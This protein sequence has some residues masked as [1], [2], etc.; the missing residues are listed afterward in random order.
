VSAPQQFPIARQSAGVAPPRRPGSVRRTTSIDSTWPD[1]AAAPWIMDGRARDILTPADGSDPVVLDEAGYRLRISPLREILELA[2]QPLDERTEQLIGVRAG[3]ESRRRIV[4][5]IGDRAG[6]PLYQILDDFAGASLVARWIWSQW[7]EDWQA[8]ANAPEQQQSHGR[9]GEMRDI[10]TGFAEGSSALGPDGL[11]S[12]NFLDPARVGPLENPDDPAGW[13]AMP[14]Q[15]GPAMRRARRIDVWREA[16]LLMVDAGFQDS[17]TS[18]SGGRR[19]VHE[20]RVY[21]EIDA[22]SGTLLSLQALPL[23]LPFPECPGASVKA[24]RMVGHTVEGFRDSVLET[25][26]GTLGCTHLNDVLRG[27]A[28]VPAIARHLD[29]RQP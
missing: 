6:T 15:T 10:C 17:G 21:A 2:T 8:F 5:T 12:R 20:Y 16:D 23:I 7:H 9:K 18:P 13:H 14:T 28:D 19:G 22:D 3:G 27:L 25:L 1:G 29:Y 11:G 4:S 26:P 24:A